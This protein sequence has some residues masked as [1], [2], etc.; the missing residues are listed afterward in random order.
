[1]ALEDSE[2]KHN[3]LHSI[4]TDLK[5]LSIVFETDDLVQ[6][7]HKLS[8]QVAALQQKIMEHLPQIQLMADVSSHHKDV[9]LFDYNLYLDLG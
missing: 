8:Y 3:L 5:E 9:I 2:Q 1:M 6:S 4:F 7:V